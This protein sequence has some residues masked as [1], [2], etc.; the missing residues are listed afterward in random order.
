MMAFSKLR[1]PIDMFSS[2]ARGFRSLKVELVRA[3]LIEGR[4]F[5]AVRRFEFAGTIWYRFESPVTFALT[6]QQLSVVQG[7]VEYMVFRQDQVT[8]VSG[9]TTPIPIFPRNTSGH[10]R[11]YSGVKYQNQVVIN[12]GG[13]ATPPVVLAQFDGPQAQYVDY[14]RAKTADATAQRQ[15]V[16]GG[17]LDERLL[18]PGFY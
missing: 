14:D 10:F 11:E 18:A 9:F 7:D 1:F 2:V 15:S 4:E 5:R 16:S 12:G 3:G 17:G 13:S 6:K 8:A